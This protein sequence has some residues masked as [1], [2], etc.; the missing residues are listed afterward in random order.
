VSNSLLAQPGLILFTVV[1]F[2][3]VC[4][5]FWAMLRPERL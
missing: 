3:L 2:V 1:S 5:L 4:Y